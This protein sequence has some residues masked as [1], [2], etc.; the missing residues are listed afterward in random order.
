MGYPAGNKKHR[1]SCRK[2]Q[3]ILRERV[4]MYKVAR[5][6]KGHNDHYKATYKIYGF[7][8][9]QVTIEILHVSSHL[10]QAYS[11]SQMATIRVNTGSNIAP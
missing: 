11:A 6:I 1:C 2:I 4:N 3:W 7:D 5:V 8:T 10:T 9:L